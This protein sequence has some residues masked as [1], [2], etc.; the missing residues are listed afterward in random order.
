MILYL[1]KKTKGGVLIEEALAM[2]HLQVP[3]CYAENQ[4]L[5]QDSTLHVFADASPLAY[6]AAA[7][8]VTSNSNGTTAATLMV[9]KS[10]VA[11]IK[12]LTLAQLE[13]MGAVLAARL[14]DYV[15]KHY[16]GNLGST[17]G[18]TLR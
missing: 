2:K 5:I 7:Y 9:A 17:F 6:G 15:Q 3:R 13:V 10:R 18:L 12:E 1:L 4:G 11:L 14:G 16:V 8:L